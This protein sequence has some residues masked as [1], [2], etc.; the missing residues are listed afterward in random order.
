MPPRPKRRLWGQRWACRRCR[1]F[2]AI[3]QALQQLP[4]GLRGGRD[5]LQTQGK[6]HA[7]A[8]ALL[9]K[10]FG[11]RTIAAA[12]FDKL[13]VLLRLQLSKNMETGQML[14][15]F[16]AHV[17]CWAGRFCL[18]QSPKPI[19][20]KPSRARGSKIRDIFSSP[21]APFTPYKPECKRSASPNSASRRN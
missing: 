1:L 18:R 5:R 10:G 19:S 2:R 13:L 4:F 12:A 20:C 21:R 3:P 16:V 8:A 9:K 11:L 7:Q 17:K 6:R 14:K 15:R